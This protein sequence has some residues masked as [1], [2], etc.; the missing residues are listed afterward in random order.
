MPRVFRELTAGESQPLQ[1]NELAFE[2]AWYVII[3]SVVPVDCVKV[4]K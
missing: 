3:H 4:L 1:S 2:L